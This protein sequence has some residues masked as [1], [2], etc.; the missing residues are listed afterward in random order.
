MKPPC[1]CRRRCLEV[2]LFADRGSA[3][4]CQHGQT[5]SA[6]GDRLSR[7]RIR[8]SR[9]P[10]ECVP[11]SGGE[12]ATPPALGSPGGQ[13]EPGE[14]SSQ[15]RG[16]WSASC[17]LS[18]STSARSSLSC[19]WRAWIATTSTPWA[20]TTGIRVSPC[21]SPKAACQS[22][23]IGPRW[24]TSAGSHRYRQ[25]ATGN[26]PSLA[27]TSKPLTGPALIGLVRIRDPDAFRRVL[28]LWMRLITDSNS[29]PRYR[30]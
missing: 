6:I 16:D 15:W 19:C 30:I 17:W 14:P 1:V 5:G 25:V 2:A 11:L 22:W 10:G 3:R 18:W 4:A 20:S 13:P 23:A 26:A 12:G 24:R 29:P 7:R 8:P 9:T 21:P 27:N 28:I